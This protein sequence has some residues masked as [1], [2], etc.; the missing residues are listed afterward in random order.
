[1]SE[2]ESLSNPSLK[3]R[4]GGWFSSKTPSL[5]QTSSLGAVETLGGE[6]MC[7]ERMVSSFSPSTSASISSL[8]TASKLWCRKSVGEMVETEGEKWEIAHPEGLPVP[9]TPKC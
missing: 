4:A 6:K 5:E 7:D 9:M 1:M 2:E 8:W 3:D